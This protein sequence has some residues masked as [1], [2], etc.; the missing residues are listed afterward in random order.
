MQI[1]EMIYRNKPATELLG[2]GVYNE[3]FSNQV[4][5]SLNFIEMLNQEK[6]FDNRERKAMKYLSELGSLYLALV[7]MENDFE[8]GN[9]D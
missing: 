1:K 4:G 5:K 3:N 6:T 7:C 9:N 8:R 2:Y